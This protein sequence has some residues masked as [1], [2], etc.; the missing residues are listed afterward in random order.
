MN[1]ITRSRIDDGGFWLGLLELSA[2]VQ[3]RNWEQAESAM[4]FLEEWGQSAMDG[5]ASVPSVTRVAILKWAAAPKPKES[6]SALAERLKVSRQTVY[7]IIRRDAKD[8]FEQS[9]LEHTSRIEAEVKAWLDKPHDGGR[10]RTDRRRENLT[11][12]SRRLGVSNT[13]IYGIIRRLDPSWFD[14]PWEKSRPPE[15]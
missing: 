7:K 12:L 1:G 10:H 15:A 5:K 3:N 11:D 9:K 14:P 13:M 8:A 2:A 6:V 4:K